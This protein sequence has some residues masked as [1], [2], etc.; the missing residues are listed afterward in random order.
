M[1]WRDEFRLWQT[2]DQRLLECN[3]RI[4]V[5]NGVAPADQTVAFFENTGH[6]CD[7]EPARFT[8]RDASAH[9]RESFAEERADEMRLEPSRLRPFHLL[10]DRTD[11]VRVHAL[12]GQLSLS[13][14]LFNCLYI[15]RAV[16]LFEQF[17]PG[18]G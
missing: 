9:H 1:A 10:T 7:L 3:A 4:A 18:L 5:K 17:G 12:R 11:R 16:D 14:Q 13:N 15:D 2:V 8:F 6:S